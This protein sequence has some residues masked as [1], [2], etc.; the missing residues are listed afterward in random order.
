[1]TK[2]VIVKHISAQYNIE[3][4]NAEAAM[5]KAKAGSEPSTAYTEN[6]QIGTPIARPLGGRRRGGGGVGP[7]Q[8]AGV[9]IMAERRVERPKP[10]QS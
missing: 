5:E 8:Q 7:A 2:F 4:E 3:A 10:D 6:W 9:P 1:M